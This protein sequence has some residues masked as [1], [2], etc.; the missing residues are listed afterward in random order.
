MRAFLKPFNHDTVPEQLIP[1]PVKPGLQAQLNDPGLLLQE[2]F[3]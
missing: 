1:S 3:A 2:A